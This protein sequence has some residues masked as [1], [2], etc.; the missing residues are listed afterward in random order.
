M[1]EGEGKIELGVGVYG[2]GRG[3]GERSWAGRMNF[4]WNTKEVFGS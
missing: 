2:W 1:G 4:C 3:M